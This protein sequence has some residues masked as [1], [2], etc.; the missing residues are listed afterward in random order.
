M[1]RR[2]APKVEI[3][4]DGYAHFYARI[5]NDDKK[6][7]GREAEGVDSQL[8]RM[9]KAA[10]EKGIPRDRRIEYVDNDI[11]ASEYGTKER[12]DFIRLCGAVQASR[13]SWVF[14][15][16]QQRLVRQLGEGEAF[17]RMIKN[18]DNMMI[19][20]LSSGDLDVRTDAGHYAW[21]FGMFSGSMESHNVSRRARTKNADMRE[22]GHQDHAHGAT[23]GYRDNRYTK[24]DA[25]QAAILKK[26]MKAV[27]A[28]T[29]GPRDCI[30]M[31]RDA[32]FNSPR[33]GKPYSVTAVKYML[34]N[35]VYAG[36]VTH[37]GKIVRKSTHIKRIITPA[38]H[39][40]VVK[41]LEER[42][43]KRRSASA[44]TNPNRNVR[45]HLLT[46]L[47]RCGKPGCGQALQI[48]RSSGRQVW[49]CPG[50]LQ[51]GCG[52]ITRSYDLVNGVVDA[53]VREAL[54]QARVSAVAATQDDPER[55]RLEAEVA[56][57]EASAATLAAAVAD[58]S[59][60][61][62]AEDYVL[63]IG[64]VRDGITT[65]RAQLAGMVRAA[66]RTIPT[67][68][69]AT[70]ADTRP[71]TLAER[72]Q[73]AAELINCVVVLP[74]GNVG[75]KG[76]PPESVQVFPRSDGFTRGTADVP[77]EFHTEELA[78]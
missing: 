33:T 41:A 31:L 2:Y 65:R 76:A 47:L 16:E 23:F 46:G 54:S 78:S 56:E 4:Y 26:C 42:A 36:Y 25:R 68:A 70:W 27:I 74:V 28:G 53:W 1:A 14:A 11:S 34:T 50:R 13:N 67:D 37:K 21:T 58:P 6:K 22:Q 66:V 12:E 62:T 73:M 72:R 7:K 64:P 63:A 39:D 48:G 3:V 10:D 60:P 75:H 43:E 35:P 19:H 45:V 40:A 32:G 61:I 52:G 29:A 30:R 44:K 77:R 55:A 57:L 8:R 51:G 15:T 49:R 5:S 69:L 24:I 9:H 20:L 38:E 59:S 18:G 71:E 17:E